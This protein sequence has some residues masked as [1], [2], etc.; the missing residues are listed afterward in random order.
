MTLK[1]DKNRP[2]LIAKID[3]KKWSKINV[4]NW[5]ENNLKL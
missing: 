4:I 3:A 2:N 1:I 5:V